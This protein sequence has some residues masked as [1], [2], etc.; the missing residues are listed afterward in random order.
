MVVR[1]ISVPGTVFPSCGGRNMG[2]S[3][4]GGRTDTQR[5]QAALGAGV[6]FLYAGSAYLTPAPAHRHGGC[7]LRHGEHSSGIGRLPLGS[8]AVPSGLPSRC[9]FR[10][11]KALRFFL[12]CG[13]CLACELLMLLRIKGYD[14]CKHWQC[15][16]AEWAWPHRARMWPVAELVRGRPQKNRNSALPMSHRYRGRE[17]SRNQVVGPRKHPVT[18]NR[19]ARRSPTKSVN[20]RAHRQTRVIE[21]K[22]WQ[23]SPAGLRWH[24]RRLSVRS[25]KG[26]SP[27]GR[28]GRSRCPQRQTPGWRR[29]RGMYRI[30]RS[31]GRCA[32][33]RLVQ[34]DR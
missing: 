9:K 7:F 26:P 32:C 33:R 6:S 34:P 1:A 2:D 16:R 31:S 28:P 20:V 10:D 17:R 19:P 24:R 3:G 25:P 15:L 4:L 14:T 29:R 18:A 8:L 22:R 27:Q 5:E 12:C 13:G 21:W 11:I 23:L 30:C